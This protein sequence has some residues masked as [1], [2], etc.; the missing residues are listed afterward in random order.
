M[1]AA[2]EMLDHRAAYELRGCL[3]PLDLRIN[4]QLDRALPRAAAL[5]GLSFPDGGG[6]SELPALLMADTRDAA[7]D[8]LSHLEAQRHDRDPG[9]MPPSGALQPVPG[10]L[11]AF[12]GWAACFL[13]MPSQGKSGDGSSTTCDATSQGS[14]LAF[15]VMHVATVN[16]GSFS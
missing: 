14:V 15:A 13:R 6:G 3:L 8:L 7:G 12:P 5:S 11:F 9:R 1:L 4:E 10:S 2:D 16:V